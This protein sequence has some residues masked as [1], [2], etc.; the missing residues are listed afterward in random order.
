MGQLIPQILHNQAMNML[1][2]ACL[3]FK[4]DVNCR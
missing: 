4:W 2:K 1:E 3:M